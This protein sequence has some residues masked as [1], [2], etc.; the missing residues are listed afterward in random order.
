MTIRRNVNI[1]TI[2]NTY[3]QFLE[4]VDAAKAGVL[5]V[6]QNVADMIGDAANGILREARG[7]GLETCNC[8]G[9]REIEA[10]I[11][12]M[13]LRKNPNS[14]I[15]A[16]IEIGSQ[17]PA[18]ALDRQIEIVNRV[19]AERQMEE[20]AEADYEARNGVALVVANGFD[21]FRRQG[22]EFGQ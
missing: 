16:A 7:L 8:D 1:A 6:A 21:D 4:G 13:L 15:T 3:G 17:S 5:P 19:T 9:I 20:D 12:E 18:P 14:Q 11:F 10:L 22:G 2:N